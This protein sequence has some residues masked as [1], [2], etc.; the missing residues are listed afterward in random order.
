LAL[1]AVAVIKQT[2]HLVGILFFLQSLQMAVV[3]VDMETEEMAVLVAALEHLE[4]L[5]QVTRLA[6]HHHKA[7]TVGLDSIV[8]STAAAAVVGL[9]LLEEMEQQVLVVT[10]AQE[11]HQ[12]SLARL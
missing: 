2:A 7:T 12:V 11:L 3:V 6:L 8:G 5:E 10:V 1:A 4:L 9:V